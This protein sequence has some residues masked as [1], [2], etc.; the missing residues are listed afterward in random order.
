MKRDYGLFRPK[1]ILEIEC[2][3]ASIK[4]L[5][6]LILSIFCF[7]T[8]KNTVLRLWKEG[9]LIIEKSETTCLW[10]CI[11]SRKIAVLPPRVLIFNRAVSIRR[12]IFFFP[13]GIYRYSS[14]TFSFTVIVF[15]E[16]LFFTCCQHWTSVRTIKRENFLTNINHC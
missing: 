12:T 6:K 7:A 9:P 8:A 16:K 5:T 11:M 14:Q 4:L 10:T 3:L 13:R 2:I 15:V 1:I